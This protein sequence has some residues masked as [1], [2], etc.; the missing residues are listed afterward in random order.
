MSDFNA[1]QKALEEKYSTNVQSIYIP[2]LKDEVSFRSIKV[3]EQK[4]I[5]KIM[6]DA[7]GNQYKIY[8][9]MLGLIKATCLDETFDITALNELDRIKILIELYQ[10]NFFSSDISLKCENCGLVNDIKVDFDSI[11]TRLN[12]I[13]CVD[14]VETIGGTEFTINYPNVIRMG[15]YYKT[16]INKEKSVADL[17]DIYDQFI[18]RIKF[19]DMDVDLNTMTI[20]EI[21]QL[22]CILPQDIIFSDTGLINIITERLFKTFEHLTDE[23]SC[24]KCQSTLSGGLTIQDFFT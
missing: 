24:T 1:I 13:D 17:Y 12:S 23:H 18:S 11:V 15:K 5:T 9:A 2:S 22:L 16:L 14:I 21:G 19:D 6:I 7:D 20:K 4:T 10:G 8:Q 3:G